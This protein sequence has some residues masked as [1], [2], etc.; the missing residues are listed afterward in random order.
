MFRLVV[1]CL[2]WTSLLARSNTFN[3]RWWAADSPCWVCSLGLARCVC[4]A[5]LI[6]AA[7]STFLEWRPLLRMLEAE[8]QQSLSLPDL[9]A[10]HRY[11]RLWKS[12]AFVEDLADAAS[13]FSDH[14]EYKQAGAKAVAAVKDRLAVC[15]SLPRVPKRLKI[16]GA[17]LRACFGL[18]FPRLPGLGLEL[19]A[20]EIFS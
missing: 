14:R 15:R 1:R 9:A 8:A 10:H 12:R 6:R 17:A 11:P 16:Q 19:S 13:G 5:S 18:S 7:H 2:R 4:A 3:S 20:P